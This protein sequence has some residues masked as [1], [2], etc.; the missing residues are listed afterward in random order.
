MH[1]SLL[2]LKIPV[3]LSCFRSFQKRGESAIGTITR[4]SYNMHKAVVS[5]PWEDSQAYCGLKSR[6]EWRR[7]TRGKETGHEA[8]NA[9]T[10]VT[11][12][13]NARRG[14]CRGIQ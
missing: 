14:Q 3:S 10:S 5:R 9:V 11:S 1:L 8:E 13:Q 6:V 4:A 12:V 7:V 2:K